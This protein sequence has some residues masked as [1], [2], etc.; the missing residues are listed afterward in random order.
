MMSPYNVRKYTVL[1]FQDVSIDYKIADAFV[2]TDEDTGLNAQTEISC[3]V[4]SITPEVKA[5][6]CKLTI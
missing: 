3:Y 1:C 2:V 4:D 5:L 6:L